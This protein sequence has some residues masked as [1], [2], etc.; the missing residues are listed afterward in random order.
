MITRGMVMEPPTSKMKQAGRMLGKAE[1]NVE[2][3]Y[4][5]S[6]FFDWEEE[7]KFCNNSE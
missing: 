1:T 6:S 2:V 4:T 3:V 7:K 5:L